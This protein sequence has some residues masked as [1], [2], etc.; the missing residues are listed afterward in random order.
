M[1]R[2][3]TLDQHRKGRPFGQQIRLLLSSRLEE[4]C[5]VDASICPF[6]VCRHHCFYLGVSFVMPLIVP[7]AGLVG[8]CVVIPAAITASLRTGLLDILI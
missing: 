5:Q 8:I 7:I 2:P 6:E 4:F 3:K 1:H